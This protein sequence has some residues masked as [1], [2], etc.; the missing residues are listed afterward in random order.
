MLFSGIAVV[1]VTVLGLYVMELVVDNQNRSNS[2][3]KAFPSNP[4]SFK[5][6]EI[7]CTYRIACDCCH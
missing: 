5:F 6:W 2:G 4:F 1:C 3:L 7:I